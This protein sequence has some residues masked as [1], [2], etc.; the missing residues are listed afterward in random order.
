M[1]H[2]C[3]FI[4]LFCILIASNAQKAKEYTQQIDT[5]LQ[6]EYPKK[7][8]GAVVLISQK[9]KIIFEKAY[10]LASLKPK[11]KMKTQMVFQIASMSKQFVSAAILQLVE[12][13]K[14]S[15][16]D[17]IQKYV[18]S[19]PSK[20]HPITIHHLL[21]QTSGI[22]EYFDVDDKVFYLLA[23]E[24]TP[25][26]LI[27][28]YKNEPLI[29][30][31]GE[32]WSYSNSNYPL[33]GAALENITGMSL[34]E[35][36]N[37]HIFDPLGMKATGLWYREDTPKK[38]IVTGYNIKNGQLILAP[39]MVGS[40]LYASGGIVSTTKDLFLW[41]TDFTAKKVLSDFI[42]H[43]LT[44]EKKTNDGKGTGY[45]YGFLLKKVNESATVQHGGN[46]FGFTSY[47]M[48]LPNEATFICV[49]SNTKFDRTEKISK[50]IA[51]V[52]LDN[53]IQ[54]F[55]KKEI[56]KEQLKEYCGV[57]K[58]DSA[59]LQRVFEI[60]L[61]DNE[62]LLYDPKKPEASALLTPSEKDIFILKA[63]SA[64]IQFVRDKTSKIIGLTIKQKDE[65][66][67]KKIK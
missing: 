25:Q 30:R 65:Y 13:G 59:S 4:F 38:Q 35:Y 10:G 63:A 23:Q 58:L 53:P 42:V 67:F 36:L 6:L 50:Y 51:S 28:Y 11:R 60:R 33:L 21:S 22:P 15:L 34:K 54:I 45:G 39:K 8:P 17:T 44:T 12:A 31:P 24:H 20:E 40:A 26:Q 62:L 61:Y 5:F 1:K 55:S 52:L 41:N 64:T 9:G 3:L 57:Y 2:Y 56:S 47:G 46:L 48:Y 43:H 32:K 14:M 49:L 37:E 29:F 18:P 16:S 19:Y 7:E 27:D 66:H